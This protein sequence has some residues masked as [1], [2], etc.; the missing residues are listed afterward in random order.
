[1]QHIRDHIR[2]IAILLT[3]A[4][5]CAG[6]EVQ[7]PPPDQGPFG[8]DEYMIGPADILAIRVWKNP[9]LSIEAVPVRPD[10]KISVPLLNDVQAAGR[11]ASELKTTLAEGFSEFVTAPDVTVIVA[12]INSKRVHVV[13]QVA[14]PSAVP[15]SVDMRVLDAIAI[16]GGFTPF[17]DSGDV[18][19]L[20]TQPDGSVAEYRFNY[21]KFLRGGGPETNMLLQPG[22]TIVVPD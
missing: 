12:Q 4:A 9:E 15:L 13:G 14:Q 22:D 2:A 10:G 5:G 6:R 18:Q 8:R 1:M 20:R 21:G 19:V 3:L 17:A 16:A 11:T 7:P